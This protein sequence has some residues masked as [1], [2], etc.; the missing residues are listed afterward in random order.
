MAGSWQLLD[1]PVEREA[2]R[3]ALTRP[4]C[5]GV[6]VIGAAGVGKTTLARTV[7]ES[8]TAPVHWAA[9][10]ETSR[11]IPLCYRPAKPGFPIP[12][13]LARLSLLAAFLASGAEGVISTLWAVEDL[14][15]TQ[16]IS[17]GTGGLT[18]RATLAGPVV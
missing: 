7:T 17:T 4:D 6:V 2:M 11:S 8:L 1:R 14:S 9:C 18:A 10:T 12:A 15:T 3:S 13:Y 5:R 16:A